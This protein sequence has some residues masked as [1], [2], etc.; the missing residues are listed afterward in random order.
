MVVSRKNSLMFESS[1]HA[2]DKT[3]KS[4]VIACIS[5]ESGDGGIH[6][7]TFTVSRM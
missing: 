5:A 7:M 1:P 3:W 4:A 6:E 2:A